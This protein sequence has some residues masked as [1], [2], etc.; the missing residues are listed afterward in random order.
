MP[1]PEPGKEDGDGT[2]SRGEKH[3]SG[4][5]RR[6]KPA[7]VGYW[8]LTMEPGFWEHGGWLRARESRE[9]RAEETWSSSDKTVTVILEYRCLSFVDLTRPGVHKVKPK[10]WFKNSL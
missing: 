2:R 5:H 6:P 1:E 7:M 4:I 8:R 3:R 10:V 9:W